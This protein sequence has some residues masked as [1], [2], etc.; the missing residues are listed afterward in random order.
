MYFEFL[1]VVVVYV[2]ILVYEPESG[3]L[4]FWPWPRALT[5]FLKHILH[6]GSL[7]SKVRGTVLTLA[8]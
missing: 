5:S 6:I 4:T 1:K 3:I 8:V 2:Y 7:L